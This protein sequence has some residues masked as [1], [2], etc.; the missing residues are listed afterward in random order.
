MNNIAFDLHNKVPTASD[1][2]TVKDHL[3]N[4][5]NELKDIVFL[6]YL[7]DVELKFREDDWHSLDLKQ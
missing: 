1:D 5:L 6:Q 3:Q 2:V 7:K 4:E